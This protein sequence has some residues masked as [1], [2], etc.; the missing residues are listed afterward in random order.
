MTAPITWTSEADLALDAASLGV[1]AEEVEG[2]DPIEWVALNSW[3]EA[4]RR[5]LQD[6]IRERLA[7][8]HPGL[9][10]GRLEDAT[11]R[12]TGL[13]MAEAYAEVRAGGAA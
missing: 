5:N 12:D 1:Q 13:A 3:A 8:Q 9:P 11:L 4:A 7:G 6:R 2:T 10:S